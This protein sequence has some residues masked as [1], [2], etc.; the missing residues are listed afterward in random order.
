MEKEKKYCSTFDTAKSK[1][2]A[3]LEK[4]GERQVNLQSEAGRDEVC[5]EI[6][7]SVAE[8]NQTIFAEYIETVR[9]QAEMNKDTEGGTPFDEQRKVILSDALWLEETGGFTG[10]DDKQKQSHRQ[11]VMENVAKQ[12]GMVKVEKEETDEK[13]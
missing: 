4:Y 13:E 10:L 2:N 3:I 7:V 8:L 5:E 1:V 6:M 12:A 9:F 11:E